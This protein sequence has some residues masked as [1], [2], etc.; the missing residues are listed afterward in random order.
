MIAQGEFSGYL[1]NLYITLNFTTTC[2]SIHFFIKGEG[3]SKKLTFLSQPIVYRCAGGL[4][5]SMLDSG[6]SSQGSSP[7]QG[8]C[9]SCVL[10]QKT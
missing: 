6:A 7:G 5:V 3:H 9:L 8:H 2:T 1:Q 10:G 4:M